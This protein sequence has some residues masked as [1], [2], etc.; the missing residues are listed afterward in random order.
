MNVYLL[1]EDVDLGYTVIDVYKSLNTIPYSLSPHYAYKYLGTHKEEKFIVEG[2]WEV[3]GEK[4]MRVYLYK[5]KGVK[6]RSSYR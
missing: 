6:C 1:T 3:Q 5:V 2:E 4:Y